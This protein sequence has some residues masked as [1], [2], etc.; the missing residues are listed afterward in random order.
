V[1]G[2]D[3]DR[4]SQSKIL[5]GSYEIYESQTA[6]VETRA[7]LLEVVRSHE[8]GIREEEEM[9][10]GVALE[11]KHFF[12]SFFFGVFLSFPFCCRGEEEGASTHRPL[13]GNVE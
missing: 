11:R 13:K 7:F 5:S 3:R 4:D 6:D 9:R 2:R 10:L 12:K 8:E 1:S